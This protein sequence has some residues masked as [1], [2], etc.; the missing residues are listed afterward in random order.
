MCNFFKKFIRSFHLFF[1][2]L[3][4]AKRKAFRY[5][6]KTAGVPAGRWEKGRPTGP[7]GKHV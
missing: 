5:N 4:L 2:G 3:A 6:K 7:D 1:P